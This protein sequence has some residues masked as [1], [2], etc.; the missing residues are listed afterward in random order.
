MDTERFEAI[1]RTVATMSTRRTA[2]AALAGMAAG[3]LAIREI[4]AG[5]NRRR[6]RRRFRGCTRCCRKGRKNLAQVQVVHASPD[7]PNVDVYVDDQLVIQ[8]L[9]FGQASGLG[10]VPA[11]T[12]NIK[13]TPA[14][15]TQPVVIDADVDFAA[16]TSYEVSATGLL[17]SIQAQVYPIPR[18]RL[19]NETTRVRIIHNSPGAPSVDVKVAGTQIFLAQN[20]AFPNAADPVEVPAG[21]YDV[22][23][24]VAGTNTVVLTVPD[25]ALKSREVYDIFAIGLVA[26]TPAFTVLPLSAKA[27]CR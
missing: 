18:S 8:N 4:D 26:G 20:L 6:R 23:V 17:A 15:A 21:A 10:D 5:Q 22:E 3:S 13:V 12:R 9:P 19:A 16:C 2:V 27:C 1:R 14:G 11:G 7:A 24:L 25:V